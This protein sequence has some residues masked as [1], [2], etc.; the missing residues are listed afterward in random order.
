MILLRNNLLTYYQDPEQRD[1]F[2]RIVSCL[3][4]GGILVTGAREH[5]PGSDAALIQDDHC[6]WVCRLQ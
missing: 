2:A 4:T 5:L 3:T 1:A 6:P